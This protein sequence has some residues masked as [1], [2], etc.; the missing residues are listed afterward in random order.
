MIGKQLIVSCLPII[1]YSLKYCP[2][3]FLAHCVVSYTFLAIPY[4]VIPQVLFYDACL[5]Q[6]GPSAG[7]AARGEGQQCQPLL[8]LPPPEKPAPL[9]ALAFS[10]AK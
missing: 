6:R 5:L 10:Q 1:K 2:H 8:S 3:R 9:S 4:P 7:D